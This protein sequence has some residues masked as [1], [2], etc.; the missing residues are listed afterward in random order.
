MASSVRDCGS[1]WKFLK[2][3]ASLFL[4]LA[5]ALYASVMRSG[6]DDV[7]RAT[8]LV[9]TVSYWPTVHSAIVEKLNESKVKYP[10]VPKAVIP[11]RYVWLGQGWRAEPRERE[12]A[13][14]WKSDRRTGGRTDES[15][16]V[17]AQHVARCV[18]RPQPLCV[19]HLLL[20]SSG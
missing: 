10:T 11:L 16:D 15:A 14:R 19:S 12:A 7:S 18:I 20:W 1:V 6:Q 5:F 3:S 8:F 17:L 2:R 13:G 4:L 9:F